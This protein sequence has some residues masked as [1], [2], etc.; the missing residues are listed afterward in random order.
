VPKPHAA[1]LWTVDD[2]AALADDG[3]RHEVVDRTLHVIELEPRLREIA[4]SSGGCTH[5]SRRGASRSRDWG[6]GVCELVS[7]T[8]ITLRGGCVT[9]QWSRE[10]AS[11]VT[12]R[13]GHA[14][15]RR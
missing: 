12:L 8:V 5:E 2:L 10:T 9:P 11:R 15:A 14:V 1:K 3:K 4:E 6:S 7:T 13:A